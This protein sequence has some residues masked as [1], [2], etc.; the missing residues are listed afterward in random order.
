MASEFD[1]HAD[2]GSDARAFLERVEEPCR[3]QFFALARRGPQTTAA[4]Q[5][6]EP[7]EA[8]SWRDLIR[9]LTDLE[10]PEEQ[11]HDLGPKIMEHQRTLQYRMGRPVDLGVALLDFF[12]SVHPLLS[13]PKIVDMEQYLETLRYGNADPLTGLANRRHMEEQLEREIYRSRRYKLTFAV[14]YADLDDFKRVNDN[15][16]HAM[17]DDVLRTFAEHLR[18]HL[19]AEDLAARFGGEEFVVL[20]PQTDVNGAVTLAERLRSELHQVRVSARLRISFSGG[21]AVFPGHGRNAPALLSHA[22]RGLYRAKMAGKDR[23]VIE[24]SE[25]RRHE[26]VPV[27]RS[28]IYYDERSE[29]RGTA[30]DISLSG[31]RI[32][33]DREPSA[34]QR[35]SISLDTADSRERYLV[36][37]EVVWVRKIRRNERV[38]FGAR[39]AEPNREQVEQI[40]SAVTAAQV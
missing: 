30:R 29:S 17:G 10:L 8:P 40:F 25:K 4:P 28:L 36:G 26:R 22:D 7:G 23:V 3:N 13:C 1:M 21:L 37:A 15:H 11:A 38:E 19:R 35:I 24:P 14:L 39:Y 9:A 27:S 33:A 20:M 12:T 5:R 18:R 34:G 32:A 16:G 6:G 2:T 31:V